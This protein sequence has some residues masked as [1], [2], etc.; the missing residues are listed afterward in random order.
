MGAGDS[1]LEEPLLNDGDVEGQN[2]TPEE[3]I[4]RVLSKLSTYAKLLEQPFSQMSPSKASWIAFHA[5]VLVA[6]FAALFP[7]VHALCFDLT[8]VLENLETRPC[9]IRTR[10]TPEHDPF[11]RRVTFSHPCNA[12]LAEFQ[13]NYYKVLKLDPKT[14]TAGRGASWP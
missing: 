12:A 5:R 11:S 3:E 6:R 10:P 14:C 1:S 4:K 8:R 2:L 7:E 13:N 9:I